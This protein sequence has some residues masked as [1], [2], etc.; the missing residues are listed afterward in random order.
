MDIAYIGLYEK[1]EFGL[2]L[3]GGM[4]MYKYA[5]SGKENGT[6]PFIELTARGCLEAGLKANLLVAKDL[7][8]FEVKGYTQVCVAGSLKCNFGNSEFTG[9]LFMPPVIVGGKV[10]IKTKGVLQFDLIDWNGSVS[11]FDEFIIYPRP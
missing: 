8:D 3:I 7:V 5:E 1:A 4:E 11:V 2:N 10:K 6:Q 9:K